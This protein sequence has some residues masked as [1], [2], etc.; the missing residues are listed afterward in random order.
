MLD[1]EQFIGCLNDMGI[2]FFTGIPDSQLAP[3]CDYLYY[4]YGISDQHI[5][6]SNEGNCLAMAVGYH[7]ATRKTPCV[8]MQNSGLGN[9]VNPY[10]SLM[11]PKVYAIPT[12]FIIGWRGEP[13]VKDEPQHLF[14]GEITLELLELLEIDYIVLNKDS[15]I[16]EIQG[17]TDRI[18]GIT[19][20]GKSLAFVVGKNTF[21]NKNEAL[22]TNENKLT[23]E[24][25]IEDIINRYPE[26]TYVSTTGKASRELFEIRKR[27]R[28]GHDNDFLTVGSM[29]HSSMIA[30]GIAARKKDGWIW[31]LDGDGAVLMHMGALAVIGS[32]APGNFVHVIL[33]NSAHDS[34]GGMPTISNNIDLIKIAYGCGYKHAISVYNKDQLKDTL[35]KIRLMAGP[36]L[37]DVKT[38]IGSRSDLGRPTTTTIQNK[39]NF[40][41]RLER[42]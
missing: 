17:L 28:E 39:I 26:D 42:V 4:K 22:Y 13:G 29:G 20:N 35:E 18:K 5:I 9:T 38:A 25:I 31:C 27:R 24:E 1:A 10:T 14:Q 33:N 8:Y 15:K 16:K 36:A 37:L 30:L 34:V 7:L 12:V 41:N 32:Y 40:M 19:N 2:D 3:F 6:G 21:S 11:S 23:R